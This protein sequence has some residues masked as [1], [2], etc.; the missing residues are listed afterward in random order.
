VAAPSTIAD[1]LTNG[2]GLIAH[3]VERDRYPDLDVLGFVLR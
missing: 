2:Y 1:P 3:C